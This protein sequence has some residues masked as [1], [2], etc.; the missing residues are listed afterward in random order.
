[1]R[2]L[3]RLQS[4]C[5]FP[6]PPKK[7]RIIIVSSSSFCPDRILYRV[8]KESNTVEC[9]KKVKP[10]KTETKP[11]AHNGLFQLLTPN[12]VAPVSERLALLQAEF[13]LRT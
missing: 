3:N 4:Y 12:D 1:M 7:N 11:S 5:F 13:I 10:N 8:W 6:E 2:M 9:G